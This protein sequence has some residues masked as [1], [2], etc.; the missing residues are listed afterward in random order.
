MAEF[1][2]Q[3]D[4]DGR[5]YVAW[6]EGGTKTRQ[7]GL[8]FQP[9][10][11][12]PRMYETG[13]E[14]CPVKI[15]NMYRN[16]RPLDQRDSGPFYLAVIDAPSKSVWYKRS[17]MGKNTLGSIV[18][19]IVAGTKLHGTKRFSNHSVRKTNVNTLQAAGFSRDQIR[20]VTGH[21][22]VESLDLY[23]RENDE[24]L[25]AMS[26]SLSSDQSAIATA[27]TVHRSA[28]SLDRSASASIRASNFGSFGVLSSPET[29][30][31]QQWHEPPCQI[32]LPPVQQ[33]H[34]PSLQTPP[35][36]VHHG[37]VFNITINNC[38]NVNLPTSAL[39]QSSQSSQEST[40]PI[41]LPLKRLRPNIIESD[42][43]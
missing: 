8:S 26:T 39:S 35:P 6:I 22:R 27:S 36:S 4:G 30:P 20:T 17:R 25:R 16:H 34:E 37:N 2:F 28:S 12:F 1:Q 10:T 32:P 33:R 14:R 41:Q 19:S 43:D 3:T 11:T 7:P 40:S 13:G 15:F 23:S 18:Q 21:R 9:R 24:E 38:R 5:K 31:M 42:S 29:S